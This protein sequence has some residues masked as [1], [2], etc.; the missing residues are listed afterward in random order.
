M[1]IMNKTIALIISLLCALSGGCSFSHG[2]DMFR[3]GVLSPSD[4][5][6]LEITEASPKDLG[7]TNPIISNVFCADPTSVEYEGRLYIYGTCDEQQ[8]EETGT[9]GENSYEKIKSLVMLSTDDMKNF[10][11]HGR[12]NVGEIAPW[13]VA[14][15]APSVVS[16]KESDGLTHFYMYFSNSGWGTGVLTSTSP[17]GPWSDPLGKSLIDGHTK[18]LKGCK[19]PFDP[20]AVIDDDGVGWLT[21]GGCGGGENGRIVRLGADLISLDSEI[22]KLPCQYH[23]EANELNFINGTYVYTYNTDWQSHIPDWDTTV[24]GA[25]PPVCSMVYMTTKTP[26]DY[27]SWEYRDCY[28]KNPGEQGMEYGNNHTHLQKFGGRYYLF[29]HAMLNQKEFGTTGGFRNIC[30]NEAVVDENTLSIEKVN[31][32]RKGTEQ[33]K[34]LDPFEP[35]EAETMA[36]CSGIDYHRSDDGM[37][38]ASEGDAAGWTYVC[39]ADFGKGTSYIGVTAKGKGIIEVHEGSP[40]GERIAAIKIDS[41]DHKFFCTDM[42]LKGSHDISFVIQKGVEFDSWS[43]A[44]TGTMAAPTGTVA[45]PTGTVAAPTGTM[46]APAG[47]R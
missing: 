23:F 11:Y 22:T 20:G 47:S 35:V 28:F 39:G 40:E 4:A 33:I 31:G 8:F 45:A 25:P 5:P 16:R 43:A 6:E 29:Y 42:E 15:W 9:A 44:P 18:G 24:K 1:S 7:D 36:A 27:D 37:S 3:N 10:T 34:P 17:T 32:D 30:V 46:I 26:L 41:S 13:I 19:V 2:S 14:S 12:I 21:F 38:I